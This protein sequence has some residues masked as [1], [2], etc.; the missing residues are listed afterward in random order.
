MT[1]IIGSLSPISVTIRAMLGSVSVGMKL[2]VMSS[3]YLDLET[4]DDT[5]IDVE[6]IN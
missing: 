4:L 2:R 6:Q 3:A 5:N 1:S